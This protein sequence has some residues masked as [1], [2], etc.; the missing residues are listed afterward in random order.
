MGRELRQRRFHRRYEFAE[1]LAGMIG[2]IAPFYSNRD[3]EC[4]GLTRHQSQYLKRFGLIRVGH[5]PP[6]DTIPVPYQ[7]LPDAAL[8]QQLL[9][10]HQI[11]CL[12]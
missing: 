3:H 2:V 4:L 7:A 9:K 11:A 1:H 6:R 12:S 8:F 5:M 10:H